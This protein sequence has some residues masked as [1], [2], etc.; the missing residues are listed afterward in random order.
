MKM[1][2]KAALIL[3]VL[4]ILGVPVSA[5]ENTEAAATPRQAARSF[6]ILKLP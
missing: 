3:A 2:R 5:Q 1:F 6:L 4:C